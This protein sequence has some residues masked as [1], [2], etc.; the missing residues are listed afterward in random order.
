MN[1]KRGA[2]DYKRAGV[3][4]LVV[5]MWML[6]GCDSGTT[7]KVVPPTNTQMPPPGSPGA[8]PGQATKAPAAA[9]GLDQFGMPISP[10]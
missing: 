6:V 7:P 3:M 9:N 4:L 2:G 10:K 1:G 5:A 8:G